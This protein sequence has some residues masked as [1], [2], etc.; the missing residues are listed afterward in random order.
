[1][2]TIEFKD[3]TG[4]R[5]VLMATQLISVIFPS[6]LQGGPRCRVVAQNLVSEVDK[7]EADRIIEAIK[8]EK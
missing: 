8:E 6:A 4:N 5:I 3:V 1:M 7:E 2:K